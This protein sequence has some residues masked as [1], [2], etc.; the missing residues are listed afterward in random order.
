M[1]YNN[2]VF[3]GRNPAANANDD[4]AIAP[5]V[6]YIAGSGNTTAANFTNYSAG[7]NGIIIDVANLS[8]YITAADLGFLAGTTTSPAQWTTIPAPASVLIRPGAGVNGTTRINVTFADGSITNKWLRVTV[9]ADANTGLTKPDVFYFG[10]LVGQTGEAAS[11][12]LFSV[13]SAVETSARNDPH[14]FTNPATIADVNDFNRDG[15]VDVTDQLIARASNGHTLAVL[16]LATGTV[17]PDL[18]PAASVPGPTSYETYFLQLVNLAR[19]NPTAAAAQ[20]G[21]DLNEG[22]PAGTISSAAEQPLAFNAALI[23]AAQSHSA[24]MLANQTF[25]HNEG[26]LDPVTRMQNA[27]YV[28]ASPSGS[29]ENLAA[30]GTKAVLIPLT[31]LAAGISEPVCRFVRRGSRPSHRDAQRQFR[32][33]RRRRQH[34]NV[35]GIQRAAFDSGL[36]LFGQQRAVAHRCRV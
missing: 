4:N 21:I 24:W 10:N 18:E 28:F 25:S 36:C 2:S 26:T 6:A 33:H 19:S 34:R 14:G 12:G 35:R 13:T 5:A 22:L 11:G 8:S 27:G 31:A 7:L 1:F 32:R 16:N 3:D 23:T 30:Q 15:R 20:F 17:V 29:G 9:L